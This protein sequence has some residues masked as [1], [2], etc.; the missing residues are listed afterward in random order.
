MANMLNRAYAAQQRA[1]EALLESE[2][3][4]SGVTVDGKKL[5]YSLIKSLESA[6]EELESA[7]NECGNVLPE[8]EETPNKKKMKDLLS[9]L[10]E[11][12]NLIRTKVARP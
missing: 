9:Q 5:L 6:A 12:I 3:H 7:I 11:R 8:Y 4:V 10:R 1:R 2:P